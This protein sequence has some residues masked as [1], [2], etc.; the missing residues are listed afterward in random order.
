[1]RKVQNTDVRPRIGALQ[2]GDDIITDDKHKAETFNKFF[3]C[4]GIELSEKF[5]QENVTT[6]TEEH[7]YRIA[8]R[9]SYLALQEASSIR[10]ACEKINPRKSQAMQIPPCF[11]PVHNNDVIGSKGN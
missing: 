1:M 5:L 11:A 9:A 8:P 7:I 4:I 2:V 6:K 3:S 10:S